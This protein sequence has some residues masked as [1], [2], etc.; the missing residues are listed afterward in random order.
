MVGEAETVKS[1]RLGCRGHG[2]D[3]RAGDEL[4]VG[5][6]AVHRVGD[7]EL[8]SVLLVVTPAPRIGK[9]SSP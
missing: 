3:A 5:G 9:S 6:M 8:H 7:R 4:W 1:S 2:Y